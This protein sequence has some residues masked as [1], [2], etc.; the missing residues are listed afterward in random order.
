[1]ENIESRSSVLLF[2]AGVNLMLLQLVLI[3]EFS[4]ILWSTELVILIVT[5]AYFSGYSIG[6]FVSHRIPATWIRYWLLLVALIHLPLFLFVRIA[7]GWLK[8]SDLGEIAIPLVFVCTALFLT[9]FYTIFLPRIIADQGTG[10]TDIAR[11]YSIELLGGAAAVVA[12][13]LLG[14]WWF[15]SI[16][17][18]YVSGFIIIAWCLSYSFWFIGS[19][20]AIVLCTLFVSSRLDTFSM[21]YFY[22]SYYSH[23]RNPHLLHSEHTPYQRIDVLETQSRRSLYLNGLEYFNS[24]GLESFNYYLSELP[25]TM[26]AK[27]SGI[28]S[29]SV[30][31]IGSGSMSSLQHL[32]PVFDDLTTV[33]IDAGVAKVG[34]FWFSQYNQIERISEKWSLE[35]DDAKHYLSTT[36]K[37]FDLIV[38]DV[39]AP[40]YI[41]TG[42]LF[43][44]EFYAL[45]KSRLSET[46]ILS[47]YLTG[48]IRRDQAGSVQRQILAALL[49][50][51]EDLIVTNPQDA[52]YGFVI[53][54]DNLL[55]SP[56][57]VADEMLLSRPRGSFL[58]LGS[59]EIRKLVADTPPASFDNMSIV[60]S[61]NMR[62][63]VR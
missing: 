36:G 23:L 60:W 52:P 42:L 27:S 48:N 5:V 6:Y 38:V 43:S 62:A 44:Q 22:Q 28:S 10:R 21:E 24:D 35:I 16:A 13:F 37:T 9:S 19:V 53:A 32:A 25:A 56:L 46:G 29:N 3:R 63:L 59:Y 26:L 54:G 49:A 41:Q 34:K 31:I 51:F 20:A 45:A 30:L 40:W 47:V 1:M 12:A 18:V 4:I 50:E 33:E 8:K 15:E 57:Q 39:P 14:G 11:S 2:F 58:T 55:F 7:G 17:V 61:L